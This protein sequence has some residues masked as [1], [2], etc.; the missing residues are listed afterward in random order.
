MKTSHILSTFAAVCIFLTLIAAP[1][2]RKNVPDPKATQENPQGNTMQPK[3]ILELASNEIRPI[4]API[5]LTEVDMEQYKF[6]V[7]QYVDEDALNTDLIEMPVNESQTNLDY[8]KFDITEYID[9]LA[10]FTDL[11]EL[12]MSD[13][14]NLEYLR[15]DVG[16]YLNQNT[17]NTESIEMPLDNSNTGTLEYLKF[18]VHKYADPLALESIECNELPVK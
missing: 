5:S 14:S 7:N 16:K 12:P 3:Y 2:A 11:N 13:D 8:L 17:S 10:S 15:F 9:E 6:D 4:A 1:V 18:D